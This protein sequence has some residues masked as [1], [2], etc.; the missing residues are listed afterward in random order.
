VVWRRHQLARSGVPGRRSIEASYMP[1]GSYRFR[2]A[3]VVEPD[4]ASAPSPLVLVPGGFAVAYAEDAPDTPH[5]ATN[6]LPRVRI[7]A[8]RFGGPLDAGP[9]G[10]GLRDV[11]VAAAPGG[12]LLATWVQPTPTG[13]GA[14][15]GQGALVVQGGTAF[16]PVEAVTPEENV[17]EIVA[18]FDPRSGRAVAAWA[19]RPEGTGPSVPVSQTRTVVRSAERSP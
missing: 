1:V 15:V 19:A 10:G 3:Q 14:G 11:T 13:D 17:V 12:S 8:P 6:A 16:G 5:P 2:S 9:A 18:G 7:A 4:G